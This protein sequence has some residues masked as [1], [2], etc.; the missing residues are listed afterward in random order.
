TTKQ[1]FQ[2]FLV[3]LLTGIVLRIFV[4]DTFL[5]KG[6]SMAPLVIEND[7][8][9]V[10]KFAYF[11]GNEPERNDIIVT[12]FRTEKPNAIKRV[13]GLPRERVEISPEKIVVKKSRDDDGVTL[14]EDTYLALA[15]FPL[16]GSTTITL[17]PEEYFIL[18]D[19]RFVS[20]DS[21]DLG[22]VDK[23]DIAGRV[24]LVFRMRS[25]SFFI[26]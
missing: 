1:V 4:I 25:I 24:F 8:V 20:T 21:R 5:V 10:N 22:P 2:L 16:N 7:Y 23:W 14:A 26:P 3:V 9:F 19:N 17:D 12:T 11:F 15:N 13:I 6:N 18:G